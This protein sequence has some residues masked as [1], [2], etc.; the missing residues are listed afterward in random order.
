MAN[1]VGD[2]QLDEDT[3][4]ELY[5]EE[6]GYGSLGAF[7]QKLRDDYETK[8]STPRLRGILLRHGLFS[9]LESQKAPKKF[10]RRSYDVA[11]IDYLCR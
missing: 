8:I 4:A 10:L 3:I 7:R 6:E 9:P 1:P 5:Q 2:G 11:S